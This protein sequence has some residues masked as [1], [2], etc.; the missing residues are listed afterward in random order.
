MARKTRKASG[1]GRKGSRK[2]SKGA[3]EW[4]RKMMEVYREMKKKN[5]AT[6]LGD[7]MREASKRVKQG[8]L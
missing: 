5:P 6:R 3:S 4:N 8:R 2:I 7:A 1:K